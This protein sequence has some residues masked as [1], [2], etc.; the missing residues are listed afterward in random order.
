MSYYDI[1]IKVILMKPCIHVTYVV[2]QNLWDTSC[3]STMTPEGVCG[4]G[5]TNIQNLIA[6]LVERYPDKVEVGDS[7][8]PGI[9]MVHTPYPHTKSIIL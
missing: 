4:Y 3:E 7:S 1:D 8:S 9:R 5:V 2:G 6:Q